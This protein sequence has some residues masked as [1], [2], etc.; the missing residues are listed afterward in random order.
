[1]YVGVVAGETSGDAL[2]AGLIRR[3]RERVPEARFAGICGPRMQ[4]LG[5][6]SLYP[7]DSIS[8]IGAEGLAGSVRKILRTRRELARFFVQEPPDVFVGIDVPDFNLTLEKKL[9]GA[10]IPTV[11]YVS[12]TVWAWRRYRIHKIRKAVSHMLV[13]F[14]FEEEYYQR[15]GVPVTFVGHPIADAV[16]R[17]ESPLECRKLLGLPRAATVVGLLPGSRASELRRLG[18]L[19]V[20]TAD[21]LGARHP[22]LHFVA[23]FAN[24]AT[25]AQFGEHLERH[26]LRGRVLTVEGQSRR[27]IAASDVVLVASGT[28][29]L[30]T[31]LLLKPM[32]VT[33]KVSRFTALMVRLFVSVRRFSMPNHLLENASVPEIM[34]D[35]AVPSA[36]GRE[37]G[38]FLDE[39]LRA[40]RLK[41][42]FRGIRGT[43]GRDADLLA[44]RAVIEVASGDGRTPGSAQARAGAARTES[45]HG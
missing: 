11:H 30:E 42:E 41:A 38:R 13:L 3:I 5:A 24:A 10:S 12:P 44:A 23:P 22:G 32:V 35:Q 31:A 34:Q 28:A 21:W 4:A 15:H 6:V 45:L 2:G 43:L 18:E 20:Q 17:I 29:T 36:L 39:P 37:L 25:R 19:F 14:P 7:M 40:G 16:A 1:M 9:R 33:Y 8:I 27:A 26:G